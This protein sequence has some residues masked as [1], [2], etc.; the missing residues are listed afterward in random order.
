MTHFGTVKVTAS[1]AV[2]ML[3]VRACHAVSLNPSAS[4]STT[5]FGRKR[6][7]WPVP[8]ASPVRCPSPTAAT[9]GHAGARGGIAVHGSGRLVGR[10]DGLLVLLLALIAGFGLLVTRVFENTF[11]LSDERAVDRSLEAARTPAATALSG[12]LSLVGS[13]GVIIGVLLLVAIAFRLVF[14]RWRE[15]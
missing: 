3:S 13:T 9:V 6:S 5:W 1:L 4:V 14:H 10:I 12:F 15:V 11:P 8:A 7:I 2:P